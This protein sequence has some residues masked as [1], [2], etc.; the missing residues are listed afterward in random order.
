MFFLRKKLSCKKIDTD[1]H[2]LITIV[3]IDYY[4]E[5]FKKFMTNSIKETLLLPVR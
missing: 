2:L 1:S 4:E 5:N 3:T